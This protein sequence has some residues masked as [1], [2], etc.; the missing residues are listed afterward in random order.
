MGKSLVIVESPAKAK[1]INKFLGSNFIVK[2]S[3]GHVRDLPEK[4]LGVDIENSFQPQYIL[5]SGKAKVF[6]E[7]REAAE[8]ADAIYLAP[9]PDREGEAIA[10]HIAHVLKRNPDKLHRVMFNAITR[11]SVQE[12]MANPSHINMNLVNAQQ[13][14]RVLDRLVGYQV[15]PILWKA[16]ARNLSAGRVQSVAL[17]L[18]CEREAEIEIFKPEEYWSIT[19]LLAKA[20]RATFTAKLAKIGEKKA[21][22]HNQ[23]EADQILTELHNAVYSVHKVEKKERRKKPYAPFITSTLQQDAANRLRMSNKKTMQ[24]AQQLYEGLEIGSEGSTGLI[25]Y[26]RT[27][28]TRIA[29]EA[30]REAHEFIVKTHGPSYAPEKSRVYARSDKKIQD[31]HEAIR[32]TAIHLTP[33]SIKSYLTSDQ[34]KLYQLIWKRFI[35]SQMS[36]AVF[37]ATTADI[38]AGRFI[39]RAT[40][41]VVKFLGF[42]TVYEEQAEESN[43]KE[44]EAKEGILPELIEGEPLKCQKLTPAQ[45]FTKPPARYNAASLVKLLESEGIGRPSTY[46]SIVSTLLDRK[47]VEVETRQFMPT[48]LGRTVSKLLVQQFPDLFNVSFTARMESDLD[49]IE[50]GTTDWVEMVRAF[51]VPFRSTLDRVEKEARTIKQALQEETD[52]QC[53]LC[54]RKLIIKWGKNGRFLACGGFPECKYTSPLKEDIEEATTAIKCDKCNSPMMIRTGRYGRF[55]G[56]TAYPKCK[57]IKPIGTGVRCPKD[58]CG[59]ELVEK[60]SKKGKTFYSCSR[61]PACDFA[62]WNRPIPQ[63]CPNC[64]HHYVEE[65]SGKEGA[66]TAYCPSCKTKVEI[67]DPKAAEALSS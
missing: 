49:K 5:V 34:Y 22:V 62:A 9:D 50:S 35:A 29:P 21:E 65:R 43:G 57:N 16:V 58:G 8:D 28:S 56:C 59:G 19:A 60:A 53:P 36:D 23:S 6:K 67:K 46:A 25:T 64:G 47:Y 61:Y 1:T 42:L 11:E 66:K 39:F 63:P 7:L 17:R 55:L 12:A 52:E 31:A 30:L 18:I 44:D 40:G 51:Y 24:I 27:D 3:L 54:S 41:S 48:A 45:H 20:S 14:R 15:S 33:E 10:W 2:A 4:N 32:P 37:D 13:A 26:M 38:K